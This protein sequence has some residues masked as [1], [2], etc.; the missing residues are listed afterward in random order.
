MGNDT[1]LAR[2]VSLYEW[3]A[4]DDDAGSGSTFRA[5][6]SCASLD[7]SWDMVH[8]RPTLRARRVTSDAA[9][10]FSRAAAVRILDQ[11][12]TTMDLLKL[13]IGNQAPCAR[14]E[15]ATGASLG[16]LRR[17]SDT[18]FRQGPT[19]RHATTGRAQALCARSQ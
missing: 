15:G 6:S 7:L 8:V 5:V 14:W 3:D 10:A 19:R 9:A 12:Q 13:P 18:V 2:T 4:R 16:V 1:D 17:G 11:Q